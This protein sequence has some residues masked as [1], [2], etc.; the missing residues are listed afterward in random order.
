MSAKGVVEGENEAQ[1][2]DKDN[3]FKKKRFLTTC[4]SLKNNPHH[5]TVARQFDA[6]LNEICSFVMESDIARHAYLL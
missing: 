5:V 4:G 1:N 3:S 2:E 6:E